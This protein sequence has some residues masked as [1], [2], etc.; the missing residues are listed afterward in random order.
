MEDKRNMVETVAFRVQTN[1]KTEMVYEGERQNRDSRLT[2][3]CG[4]GV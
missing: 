4:W 1:C 2:C 3:S